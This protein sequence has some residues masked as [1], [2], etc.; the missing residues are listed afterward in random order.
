MPFL[1]FDLQ[2]IGDGRRSRGLPERRAWGL[3]P[4]LP[5]ALVPQ[6][7]TAAWMALICLS[8]SVFV[9]FFRRMIRRM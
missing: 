5:K 2:A 7:L 4:G 9:T 1:R 8:R 6:A 3:R